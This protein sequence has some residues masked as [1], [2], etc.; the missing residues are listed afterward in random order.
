MY[1]VLH[2]LNDLDEDEFAT[3]LDG[4]PKIPDRAIVS[5]RMLRFKNGNFGDC[6]PIGEGVWEARFK[7]GAGYRIYYALAPG[8]V[9]LLC[10]GG[11]KRSQTSDT[12]Q[13]KKRWINWQKRNKK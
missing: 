7:W 8:K 1:N 6:K 2:Y 9:V 12:K 10:A 4:L 13:A 3:W 11:D 5:A